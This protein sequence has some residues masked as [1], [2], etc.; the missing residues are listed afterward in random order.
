MSYSLPNFGVNSHVGLVPEGR[1]RGLEFHCKL[2]FRNQIVSVYFPD[3]PKPNNTFRV[4]LVRVSPS[5]STWI[6]LDPEKPNEALVW[7]VETFT[8]PPK[9]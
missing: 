1:T 3:Q 2:G 4:G 6:G 8:V 9:R 5:Y 7:L